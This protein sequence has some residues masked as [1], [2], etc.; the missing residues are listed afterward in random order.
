MLAILLF[1]RVLL[2]HEFIS[3]IILPVA[4]PIM[5]YL[6][7]AQMKCLQKLSLG[8]RDLN[9]TK[10]FWCKKTFSCSKFLGC[11]LLLCLIIT[12]Q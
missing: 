12:H 7:A 3:R 9:Y 4:P 6:P 10:H 5:L 1:A 11:K 2:L 8:G